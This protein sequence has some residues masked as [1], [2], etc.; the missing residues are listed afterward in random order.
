MRP[1]LICL[2]ALLPV[3]APA[4]HHDHGTTAQGATPPRA[5]RPALGASAAFGPAGRLW[6]VHA[7]PQHVVLSVSDDAGRHWSRVGPV[8]AD[9]E[10]IAATG[11]NRP[12]I[13][14]G[15]AGQLLVT[16]TQPL[17]KPYTGFIRLARAPSPGA[18]FA[19]PLTVH[20][21]RQPIT[22]RFDA[23]TVAQDGRVVVSW[24]DKRDLAAARAA[25]SDYRGAAVYY[26]TSRDGG[27]SFA[28]EQRLAEH[29]CECC[30]IALAP[31]RDGSIQALWRHV[32]APNIR[33][34]AT[35][36]ITEEGGASAARRATQDGWALD[37]CPHHGPSLVEGPDGT[38]H[39]VW[40]T[41]AEG[42]EGP[43]YGQLTDDGMAHPMRL[44]DAGA[45]H[46]DLAVS[47]DTVAIA[48]KRFDGTATQLRVLRSADGGRSWGEP[49][50][51][52]QVEDAS[53][54]PF[55]L[56]HEGRF[57]VF[58]HSRAKPLGTWSLP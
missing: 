13:A 19:A 47:G 49:V 3:L 58:W 43:W 36:R 4:Q 33:D 35:A 5:A 53:G 1:I 23:I 30:R 2:L 37:A 48:W 12:K 15:K 28:A 41:G 26:A 6:A 51:V 34:H 7:E 32:F 18:G 11:D 42:R 44:P 52:A 9:P 20:R 46:A 50:T 10:P 39:A 29:S 56:V 8:N 27:V 21:D 22:H 31:R 25:G 40:F 16:W 14:F 57:H 38:L 24:I 45:A 54:Q 17:D 55:V